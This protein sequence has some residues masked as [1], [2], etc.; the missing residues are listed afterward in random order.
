[1]RYT[2]LDQLDRTIPPKH[3]VGA[4]EIHRMVFINN[5]TLLL[6]ETVAIYK[7]KISINI[8][9]A[10]QKQQSTKDIAITFEGISSFETIA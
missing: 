3:A 2:N 4:L 6:L 8:D 7:Q 10:T 1:M 5:C 9:N